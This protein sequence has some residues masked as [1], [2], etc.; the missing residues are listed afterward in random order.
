MTSVQRIEPD[1]LASPHAMALLRAKLRSIP[2]FPKPGIIFKD[3]TPL[4]N[5]PQ[6]LHLIMDLL[7]EPF[8]GRG[9]AHVVAMEARGFI[10]GSA[11]A[12]RLNA[13]FVPVRKPGKLPAAT[14]S[15]RYALEYG[16]GELHMHQGSITPGSAVLVVDDL[17]AT[18]GTAAAT[19]D[20]V[21]KQGGQI[22]ALAF[23]VELDF[24][25]GRQLL[26]ER[27]GA[28]IPVHSLLHVGAGE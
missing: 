5:D 8:V 17:L 16:E 25:S 12:L 13:G 1:L 3:I 26:V 10:F 11:I 6:A 19:I 18:G 7:A 9:I 28:S 22:A 24:L 14:D 20:L 2:D 21:R 15:V 4:L 23:V 27:A